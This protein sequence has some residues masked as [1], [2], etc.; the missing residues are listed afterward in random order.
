MS[1]NIQTP[2]VTVIKPVCGDQIASSQNFN[3][4]QSALLSGGLV[5]IYGNG[6]AYVD[7][8]L[9]I[10]SNTKLEILD[11]C[12]LTLANSKTCQLLRNEFAQNTVAASGF[13]HSVSGICTVSERGHT[14]AVGDLVYIEGLA[15]DAALLGVQTV[16]SAIAGTSW[17]F[18]AAGTG[19][20]TGYGYISKYNP[21]AGTSFTR[22]A[23]ATATNVNISGTLMTVVGGLGA[24]PFVEGMTVVG[25]GIPANTVIYGPQSVN[26]VMEGAGTTWLLSAA[27]TTQTGITV[28][29]TS[30][31]TLV[32]VHEPSHTKLKHDPVYI[33]GLVGTSSFNGPLLIESVLPDYWFYNTV[34]TTAETSTGTAQLLHDNDIAVSGK[35]DGNAANQT[36]SYTD[37]IGLVFGNCGQIDETRLHVYNCFKYSTW[38]F[39]TSKV[40]SVGIRFD[41]RSDGL[42]FEAP[43]NHV[44]ITDVIGAQ[45]DDIVSFTNTSLGTS[46][47]ALASPSGEGSSGGAKISKISALRSSTSSCVK[48]AGDYANANNTVGSFEIDGI[49]GQAQNGVYVNSGIVGTGT[50]GT[51]LSIKG[52]RLSGANVLSQPVKLN[53]GATGGFDSVTIDDVPVIGANNNISIYVQSGVY[54]SVSVNQESVNLPNAN[55]YIQLDSPTITRMSV[56]IGHLTLPA[57]VATKALNINGATITDLT[58]TGKVDG[59]GNAGWAIY[60]AAGTV[61]RMFINGASVG[62]INQFYAQA[63]G[64]SAAIDIYIDG[65]YI[66]SCN[67]FIVPYS[68]TNVFASNVN[69][70]AVNNFFFAPQST[71]TCRLSAS[72]NCLFPAA[73]AI[74]NIAGTVNSATGRGIKL[75]LGASGAT[76]PTG[77]TPI[78]GDMLTNTNATGAGVY[79]RTEA[80]AWQLVY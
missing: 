59:T 31:S 71:A 4:I 53:A 56:K 78:A 79:G 51:S 45:E 74:R 35:F 46:F 66:N 39:N 12:T 67:S 61:T 27:G 11:G 18:A 69:C 43:W 23:T 40:S 41:T 65:V 3:A 57:T 22:G 64:I 7:K 13:N 17:T 25:T 47:A 75:D 29:G 48:I 21:L 72:D 36:Q 5:Q 33:A 8:T 73:K 37:S 38:H 2:S 54:D 16:T 60:H 62:A 28:T 76:T 55:P 1:P 24:N 32:Q 49:S 52:V 63:S 68:A 30:P 58:Y 10:P 26:T 34:G 6:A 9:I 20:P 77:M 19:T 70:A 50:K 80:G 42:H 14:H 15:A 44:H